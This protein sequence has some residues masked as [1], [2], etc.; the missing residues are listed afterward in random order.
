MKSGASQGRPLDYLGPVVSTT[1]YLRERPEDEHARR[2]RDEAVQRATRVHPVSVV[3][4]AAGLSRRGFA[5][6]VVGA[7]VA[8]ESRNRSF[9]VPK[10]RSRSL[11]FGYVLRRGEPAS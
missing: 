8:T 11:R 1:A 10:L 7:A 5:E 9:R 4:Q 3:A 6:I 2:R